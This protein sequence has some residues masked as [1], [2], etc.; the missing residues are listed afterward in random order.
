M[1]RKEKRRLAREVFEPHRNFPVSDMDWAGADSVSGPVSGPD[2]LAFL[3][4][5]APPPIPLPLLAAEKPTPVMC[6]FPGLRELDAVCSSSIF[7]LLRA[8]GEA[9][10]DEV[11]S[12]SSVLVRFDSLVPPVDAAVFFLFFFIF[13][14]LAERE[15]EGEAGEVNEQK[16]KVKC[17]VSSYLS[18]GKL[19]ILFRCQFVLQVR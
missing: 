16:E 4:T 14:T 18:N 8:P 2:T 17:H 13:P 7:P 11:T 19:R 9:E 15:I 1:V 12:G 3:A 6:L 5:K 10:E